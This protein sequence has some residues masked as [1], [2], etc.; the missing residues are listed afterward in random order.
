MRSMTFM[1]VCL[2]VKIL[3]FLF[4][5]GGFKSVYTLGG[6]GKVLP[7]TGGG[8]QEKYSLQQEE[9]G[10]ISNFFAYILYGRPLNTLYH[11]HTTEI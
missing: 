6:S 10:R 5:G 1:A 8:G 11:E 2:R 4:R 9:G 3:S 7:A